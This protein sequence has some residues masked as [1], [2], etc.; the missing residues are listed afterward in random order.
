MENEAKYNGWTIID[1]CEE[2][3]LE[4]TLFSGQVFS[5][6]RT[7]E[8]EYTGVVGEYLVSFMQ[9]GQNVLYKVLHERKP[10]MNIHDAVCHFFTL[11]VHMHELAEKWKFDDKCLSGLRMLRNELIPTIFSFICSSNNNIPRITKMV[12]FLYSKGEFIM[13]YKGSRFHYFPS[14]D[15]LVNIEDELKANSFGYRARYVCD[16]A[17]YLKIS[18]E[19]IVN[20]NDCRKALLGIRG[21]GKKV[22]DCIL[23][24]GLGKHSVV[25][26]DT[27]ILN[28]ARKHFGISEIRMSSAMYDRV[29]EIYVNKYGKYAGIAQLYIFKTMVDLRSKKNTKLEM[30]NNQSEG[31]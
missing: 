25:P 7:G 18:S 20:G 29:Q 8:C 4:K 5:F 17:V 3:D 24:I 10:V 21:I 11:D 12:W 9:K 14:V 26:I 23:L 6:V 27:H 16:A 1:T 30:N 15:K 31:I 2:I 28:Y 13:E 19:S 22:A